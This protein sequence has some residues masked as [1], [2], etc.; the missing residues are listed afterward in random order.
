[1]HCFILLF[2]YLT[3]FIQ[4]AEK[5]IRYEK[6]IVQEKFLFSDLES[7]D[8]IASWSGLISIWIRSNVNQFEDQAK[9]PEPSNNVSDF[10]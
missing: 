9:L 5:E 3:L 6:Y 1:M 8:M 4:N 10:S 7:S 2:I